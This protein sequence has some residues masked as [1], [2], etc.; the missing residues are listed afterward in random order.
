MRALRPRRDVQDAARGGV[1]MVAET[2]IF[3][4]LDGQPVVCVF[5]DH[6]NAAAG[7]ILQVA[8]RAQRSHLFDASTGRRL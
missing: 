5:R 6:V 1:H 3:G 8:P 2:Q 4:K 7:S